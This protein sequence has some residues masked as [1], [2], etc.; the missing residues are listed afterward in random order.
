LENLNEEQ[1]NAIKHIDGPMLILAGAGSGKTKT[2]TSR[3]AYLIGEI[4]IDPANTLTLTFTNKAAGEMRERALKLL[5]NKEI[6]PPLLCTF[7]KFGLL[8]LK[9]HIEK[10]GRK[11]NFVIIDTDDKKRIIRNIAKELKFDISASLVASEISKYKNSL[12]SPQVIID[13]AQIPE[14]QK[15]AQIYK[16]YQ[17]NIEDDNLVDFDDLLKL[18]YEI[19]NQESELKK[20]I[21]KKY[22]YIMVDEYQDTNE[23]QF[24]LLELL[25][26]EHN[27][28]CVVGDDDQSIYGWRGAN[29][30]NILEFAN[31]F[32]NTKTIKLETNYR[33]K[34]EILD[35]AN[36][37]IEHNSSRLG[38][39]LISHK[40]EG[41]SIKT[42]HS[43]DESNESRSIAT[44]IKSLIDKGTEAKDIAVLYRINALSRSLEEG[45]TKERLSYKLI[46]GIRFYERS[47]IKDTISYLRILTNIND[48]FSLV[49]IINKP[50][51]GIGKTSIEKLQSLSLKNNCSIF[52]L[53][54]NHRDLI[55]KEIGKKAT[56]SLDEL[57]EI[58]IDLQDE[59]KDGK[60]SSL[61]DILESKIKLKAY[62]QSLP[63]GYERVL[64]IEEFYGFFQESILLNPDLQL[65]EF[66]NDI[67]LQS[68]Q[69]S[70][71]NDAISIMSIHASKGLEFEYVYVIGL[72]E[73]FFP[74]LGDDCN[75][76]EERRLGYVA[77]TRAKSHIT[78]C[79][80]DSRFYKGKRK[81][82]QK[83][84]FLGE[85]GL[86]QNSSLKITKSAI[87]KK[88]DLVKHKI[89]GIGRIQNISPSGKEYKLLINFGGNKKEIL[90]SFVQSV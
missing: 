59:I 81:I 52:S 67:S 3:L 7:H 85:A 84:R 42:I 68:D 19:L 90:S 2:L 5:K 46:G 86:I 35:A 75:I 87:F 56:L 33:S 29:I 16:E 31:I 11:N 36:L 71:E 34:K 23:L 1:L 61:L 73:E 44:E 4:G 24:K 63:D 53:H 88:G 70:I 8:F 25:A 50:K 32:A 76:E 28:L 64:N 83:S 9:F 13:K 43:A 17:K 77:I 78:L 82:M 22:T 74:L 55:L 65:E 48:D 54:K 21:S 14:Y 37:L 41:G 15:I 12:L 69:D 20:E 39:K 47:E 60:L 27:N 6:Y 79:Y 26:S 38:K 10:I 18:T 40:G 66:L 51:R 49:R 57:F 58:L 45:F 62:Y 72:E 30:R 80:C 89:F